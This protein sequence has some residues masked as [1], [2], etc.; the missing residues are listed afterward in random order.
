MAVFT[1][2][3]LDDARALLAQ[4]DVGHLQELAGIASGIENTNYFVFTSKGDYVLT[5]F[6]KLTLEQ[7]PFYIGLMAHLAERGVAVPMPQR[8]NNGQLI[9]VLH[10]KPCVL[11]T[12]LAGHWA[13]DP[14]A[15]HCERVGRELARM[16]LAGKDFPLRQE[17]L[18]GLAWWKQ[19][20]PQV[21]PFL[22]GPSAQLL[23][24]ELAAQDSFAQAASYRALPSG[25]A[26]CDLFRDNALFDESMN[27]GFIDFYFAGCDTWLF[28][29]AVTVN[30]WC[31]DRA[32]GALV[33]PLVHAF[34]SAYAAERTFTN[35]ERAAWR[36][37]LRAAA[38]RF[39]LSRLYDF[40]LPRP[41][42]NL[43]PKDPTHFERILHLRRTAA[44]VDLPA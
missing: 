11:A 31:I 4:Y 10:G 2:V 23:E 16:H 33:E 18:R 5:L 42:E 29:V 24:D 41:A 20:A 34:V 26:H 44:L 17:N 35:E 27:P 43:T 19:T 8:Q 6:E 22:P 39:W 30:D 7:L 1:R 21:L 3:T 9:G 32:T 36:W 37:M 38:L 13:P 25:P 14:T 12:R 40:H 15:R 28:D